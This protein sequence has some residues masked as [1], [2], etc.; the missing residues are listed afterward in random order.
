MLNGSPTRPHYIP[1]PEE[2]AEACAE[3]QKTW[4][5]LERYCRKGGIIPVFE[6]QRVVKLSHH[7]TTWRPPVCRTGGAH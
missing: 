6:R 2:I 1:S 4:S 5:E 7:L 3:I